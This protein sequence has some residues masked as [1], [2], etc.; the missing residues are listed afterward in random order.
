MLLDHAE[1]FRQGGGLARAAHAV[2]HVESLRGL[3]QLS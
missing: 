1:S 2:H 3:V